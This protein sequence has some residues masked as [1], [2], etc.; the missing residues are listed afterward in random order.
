MAFKIKIISAFDE[1]MRELSDLS[2]SSVEKFCKKHDIDC[3]RFLIENFDRPAPW[4]KILLLID[5][6][7]NNDYDYI[8]WI[9]ADACINNL[10]FD[11]SSILQENKSFYISK[12]FNNFNSG[13]F[14]VKNTP[15]IA[16][17][18]QKIYS[19]SEYINHIW[20]EQA[21]FIDLYEQNY[22][23]LQ[24]NTCL[25]KQN[26]LNA[27]DYSHYGYNRNKEGNFDEYSFVIHYPS[28][29]YNVRFQEIKN[30]IEKQK[31]LT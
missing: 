12:D 31:C 25:V 16:D 21:A 1:N 19:M 28:L 3:E 9:D 17:I 29:P 13:V 22:M 24:D 27:Y 5:Q 10:N 26:I 14:I 20:W 30:I 8:M 7:K 2:F 15:F 23:S 6:L 18:L 11:I 4:F